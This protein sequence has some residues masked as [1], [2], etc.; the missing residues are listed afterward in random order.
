MDDAFD[1]YLAL[2]E[3]LLE[4]LNALLDT[5]LG[6]QASQRN[7]IRASVA[8]IEGYTHC[9]RE[10][11]LV[12]LQCDAPALTAR[13]VA[14]LKSERGLDTNDRYKLTVRAAYKMFDLSPL[15][16]FSGKHWTSAQEVLNKRHQLMHPKVPSDL[17]IPNSSWPAIKDDVVWLMNQLF[18]FFK[19][20]QKKHDG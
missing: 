10:M 7:F 5:E 15:P 11:C 13:E 6:S 12:G 8:M 9:I 17:N 20:L 4:D 18:E 2:S 1:N 3:V 14:T 19:L 16:D